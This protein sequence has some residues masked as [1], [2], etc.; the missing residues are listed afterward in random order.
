MHKKSRGHAKGNQVRQGIKFPSKRALHPAH[1]GQPPIE[2][3]K[4]AGQQNK[5][6]GRADFAVAGRAGLSVDNLVQRH[7]A[8]VEISRRHEVRQ[9]IDS[10]GRLV[11]FRP[12]VAWGDVHKL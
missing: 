10:Q 4:N 3:I 7:E 12:G 2:Q 5:R 9:K 8:T 1:P 11:F 6:Q